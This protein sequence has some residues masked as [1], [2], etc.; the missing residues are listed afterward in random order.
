MSKLNKNILITGVLGQDGS[1]LAKKLYNK[2]FNIIGVHKKKISKNSKKIKNYLLSECIHISYV[3]IDLLD[4]YETSKLIKK[5]NPL[6]IFHLAAIH[7]SSEEII[8]KQN[9]IIQFNVISTFN[10]LNSILKINKKIKLINASSC[11]IYEHNLSYPQNEFTKCNPTSPYA[12][13]KKASMD[14]IKYFR[15]KYH[16]RVANAI[17]YNHESYNRSE[18][19]FSSKIIKQII[20]IKIKKRKKIV[21]GNINE[22]KDWTDARDVVDAL[23]LMFKDKNNQ[24]Y[25]IA[26][27]K[28][29]SIKDFIIIASNII[30]VKDIEKKIKIEKKI[31][32]SNKSKTLLIGNSKKIINNLKWK[33]SISFFQMIKDIVDH[34]L[35]NEFKLK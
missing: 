18:N 17:L 28:I 6:C 26:S 27:G 14:L 21:I 29:K 8:E 24:D 25:T 31:I 34:K 16:L 7:A 10:L 15:D 12:L 20:E 19:F 1:F 22:K 23:Y 35:Q 32:K 3:T 2:G 9:K 33:R 4:I 5:F 30:G 13:S 11:L